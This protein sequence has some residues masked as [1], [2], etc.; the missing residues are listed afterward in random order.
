MVVASWN[1]MFSPPRLDGFAVSEMYM[2]ATCMGK[3]GILHFRSPVPSGCGAHAC[4]FIRAETEGIAPWTLRY[5]D[6]QGMVYQ[7]V[8]TWLARPMPT[9]R[10]MRPTMS[11]P[12]LMAAAYTTQVN[13][14]AYKNQ[15][16]AWQTA[17]SCGG[18]SSTCFKDGGLMCLQLRKRITCRAAPTRKQPA[19]IIMVYLRPSF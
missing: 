17:A 7:R 14:Q 8:L 1:M 2:G 9:P 10:K 12:M 6:V 18:L 11:M 3:G 13:Q 16:F 19:P 4:F 5:R 15:T